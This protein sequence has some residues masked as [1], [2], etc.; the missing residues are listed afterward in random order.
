M[1][2]VE[3][4]GKC[5]AAFLMGCRSGLPYRGSRYVPKS[6]PICFLLSGSPVIV[7]NLWDVTIDIAEF[8]KAMLESCWRERSDDV[9]PERIGSLMADARNACT[10]Q[11]LTGAAVV[12]YGVPTAIRT[13]RRK[14]LEANV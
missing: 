7:A 13:K 1:G 4:M 3:N 8:G 11:F 12:C 10:L 6:A 9:K 14:R 2:E 5:S